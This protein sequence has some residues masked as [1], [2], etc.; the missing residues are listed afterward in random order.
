MHVLIVEDDATTRTLLERTLAGDGWRTSTA[1]DGRE[2]LKLADRREP[3]V[4]LLDYQLP[5][6]DGLQVLDRLVARGVQAP[7]VFLTGHGS[8]VIAYQALTKGAVDYL[9]KQEASYGE[10]K[11]LLTKAVDDWNGVDRLGSSAP[12]TTHGRGPRRPMPA[13][14][15]QFLAVTP[16]EGLVVCD[17]RGNVVVERVTTDLDTELV[18]TRAAA[19]AHQTQGLA[20]AA[21]DD[22]AGQYTLIRGSEHILAV[23]S[24]AAGLTLV[25]VIPSATPARECI[26]FIQRAARIVADTLGPE[27]EQQL[28]EPLSA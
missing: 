20:E 2:A 10:L 13:G 24:A 15:E 17:R 16:L 22:E 5:G 21:N 25:A 23:A 6:I 27:A 3:D 19:L 7:V 8:E 26:S 9:T 4:I 12:A 18:V 14:L 11:A 28:K 1:S